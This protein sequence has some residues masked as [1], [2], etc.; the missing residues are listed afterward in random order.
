M[1]EH[2]KPARIQ[3]EEAVNLSKI[4]R[5]HEGGLRNN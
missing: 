2:Y 4:D 1:L 5:K 3:G